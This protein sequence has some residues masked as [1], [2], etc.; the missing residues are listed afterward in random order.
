MSNFSQRLLLS[1]LLIAIIGACTY[2]SYEPMMRPIFV[3]ITAGF[4]VG[5]LWEYYQIAKANGSKPLSKLG[6]IGSIILLFVFYYTGMDLQ[7]SIWPAITFLLI[8]FSAFISYFFTG[9]NPVSNLAVTMFGIVYLT[10]PLGS[11]LPINFIYGRK[12]LLYLL[13]V[14]KLTD[15]GAYFIGKMFGRHKLAPVISPK[16]TWEGAVGGFIVGTIVSYAMHKVSLN[17]FD[18]SFFSSSLQS[19]WFGGMMSIVAQ[20]GDLSES[21]LKRDSGVKDSNRLPGLGGILDMLDSLVFT[22]PLLYFFLK[23]KVGL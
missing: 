11:M 15:V 18:E 4:I 22:A 2:F 10:L 21:M 5:A 8:L 12:W 3:L 1:I 19:L 13:L 14:T 9:L 23:L 16:K 6:I 17:V 7:T 20:I